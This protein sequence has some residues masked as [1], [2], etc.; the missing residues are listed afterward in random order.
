MPGTLFRRANVWLF[1]LSYRL[2]WFSS[3]ETDGF[4][5]PDEEDSP[6]SNRRAF[7]RYQPDGLLPCNVNVVLGGSSWPAIV[8]DVST[9]GVAIVCNSW[10]PP[11][12]TLLIELGPQADPATRTLLAHVCHATPRPSG[13]YHLGGRLIT[14]LTEEQVAAL[15]QAPA[16]E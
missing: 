14:P 10:L 4:G 1:F 8:A 13:G 15:T 2:L 12:T 9:D 7:A 11:E 5:T 16:A 6:V 3:L